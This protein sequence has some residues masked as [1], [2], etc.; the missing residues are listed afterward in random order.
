MLHKGLA[1][2]DDRCQQLKTATSD[3]WKAAVIIVAMYLITVTINWMLGDLGRINPIDIPTELAQL[4][5][6][7]TEGSV[8]T[9]EGALEAA[10][11]NLVEKLATYGVLLLL[12]CGVAAAGFLLFTGHESAPLVATIPILLAGLWYGESLLGL[13][14]DISPQKKPSAYD[15]FITAVKKG[16]AQAVESQLRSLEQAGRKVD[17]LQAD[18]VLAQMIV[19]YHR[20]PELREA[21]FDATKEWYRSNGDIARRFADKLVARQGQVPFEIDLGHLYAIEHFVYGKLRSQPA[22]DYARGREFTVL[23]TAERLIIGLLAGILMLNTGFVLFRATLT[24]R[25]G[26]IRSLVGNSLDSEKAA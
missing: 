24:R 20:E 19:R 14:S 4:F 16:R 3:M 21:L 17:S 13:D 5:R 26:R 18:Y 7:M 11:G 23:D 9:V 1:E 15:T 6:D 12:F 25:A 8:A 22:I 10:D 2:L